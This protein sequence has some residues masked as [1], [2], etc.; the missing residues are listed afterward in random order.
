ML[1]TRT[2][3]FLYALF[4][5]FLAGYLV[6]Y[7]AGIQTVPFHPDESTYIYMAEDFQI[8]STNPSLI[9]RKD[10]EADALKY[11]YRLVNAPLGTY[12]IG[13][14]EYLGGEKPLQV[15]WDWSIS[16]EE[17]KQ[18]GAMPDVRTLTLARLSSAILFPISL[19]FAY[20]LSRII[21]GENAALIAL[22]L[23]A[24]NAIY[25]LHTRRAMLESISL[26]TI[27]L[28]LWYLPQARK[29]PIW[30]G[31][32][33]GLAFTAKQSMLPLVIVGI[34]LISIPENIPQPASRYA[35]SVF[36]KIVG[37]SL[38][39]IFIFMVLNPIYWNDSIQ[40][41]KASFQE[42]STLSK[43]Q[44]ADVE[45]KQ[46]P[47]SA[48]ATSLVI[49][50]DLFFQSPSFSELS[51]YRDQTA[52]Q[53]T[54][55]LANPLNNLFRGLVAGTIYL[56]LTCFGVVISI[57]TLWGAD[58]KKAFLIAVYLIAFCAQLSFNLIYLNLPWQRYV[59]PLM[60]YVI[61]FTSEGIRY[62]FDSLK[63]K[64]LLR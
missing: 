15:D 25:L 13:L 27:Y 60:P 46:F 16:M 3:Q 39:F 61:L 11:H 58:R 4:G 49:L 18:I 9:F 19:V 44:H 53:E 62:I 51:N 57:K 2:R 50:A 59:I 29:R 52:F 38:S 34:V 1:A 55:Y 10:Q 20:L 24:T 35:I 37:F 48:P 21:F 32:V 28:V 63:K 40:R 8:A 6:V 26:V 47:Y 54:E 36:K 7:F 12:W 56:S 42:R 64:M 33:C 43:Y 22:F 30:F 45:W 5:V 17:N 23:T 14:W 31:F 41:L